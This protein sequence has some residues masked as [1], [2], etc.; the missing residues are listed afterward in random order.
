[1]RQ[2][3]AES[4]PDKNGCLYI[5]GKKARYL[6]AVLRC[7]PGD[8]LYV[9]LPGGGLQQMTVASVDSAKKR[10]VLQIA[11]STSIDSSSNE[12]S[13]K[14][15]PIEKKSGLELW[16]FQ[17]A[18]KPAK[19]ELIVRQAVECGVSRIIPVEGEFCQKGSVESVQKKSSGS[20][21][22]W[23]RIITE[24]R[25]QSG[26]PVETQ[27][28]PSLSVEKSLDLWHNHLKEINAQ[29]NN[30]SLVLYERTENTMPLHRAVASVEDVKIAALFVGAEGGISPAEYSYLTQNGVQG[31]HFATNILR[32]E[33]AA[34][35]GI[36]AVQSAVVEKELWQFKE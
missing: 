10:V 28:S 32:C 26:S 36:A 18:A 16:L 14:A 31:I 29:Q 27:I 8:M 3:V 33:T 19:M 23:E 22:R 35:Y 13:A 1:M 30:L 11:A 6:S 9:R 4:S 25:E 7:V 12:S 2:F 20:D 34:L 5:E 15:L 17:F 21:G 24:A